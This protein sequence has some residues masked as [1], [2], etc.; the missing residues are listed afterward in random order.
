MNRSAKRTRI[1]VAAILVTV[2]GAMSHDSAHAGVIF[3]TT[4]NDQLNPDG[5]CSLKEAI[6]A[7]NLDS[8][9]ITSGSTSFSTGCV[10]GSGAD[11]I[12]LPSQSVFSMSQIVDD[13]QNPFGPT[14]TPMVTSNITIEAD[15]SRLQ[16]LGSNNV[17]AFAVASTGNLTIRLAHIKG[18][19][20]KGGDGADGGGGGMGAGGAIFV[21]GSGSLTV[22]SC[23]FEGNGAIGGNGGANYVGGGGGGGGLGGNGGGAGAYIFSG[24]GG[25]GGSRGN[26]G[27]GEDGPLAA[28]VGAGGGGGGTVTAGHTVHIPY[29]FGLGGPGGAECGG[30]GG[31]GSG[32]IGFLSADG[33]NGSCPGGGG[34][35]GGTTA[36]GIAGKGG[37][38]ANGNY[39]GGGG[40]G[41]YATGGGTD[42]GNGG[43]GGGGGSG[44]TLASNL[45]GFGPSGGNGGFAGGGGAAHG[46]F[47]SAGPGSGGTFGGNAGHENGGGG[48]GLG[49][50]I[51]NEGGAVTVRNST[52]TGNYAVRGVSGGTG[53]NNGHDAGGT[54]FALNGSTTVENSTISGNEDTASGGGIVVLKTT[55]ASLT[56][57]NT[58]IANNGALECSIGSAAATGSGNLITAND[59]CPGVVTS[60]D[61]LLGPLQVTFPGKL[62]TM[63]LALSSP[64]LN[65]ADAATSLSMDQRGVDRPQGT[66]FDIGAYER[67]PRSGPVLEFCDFVPPPFDQTAHLTTQSSPAVGGVVTPPSGDYPLDSVQAL[68]ATANPGYGFVSW[69][70]NVA[71]PNSNSTFV[72]M[73]QSQTVTANFGICVTRLYGRGVP[74]NSASPPRVDLSWSA[75]VVDHYNVLRS[76]TSGGPYTQVGSSTTNAFSDRTLGLINGKTFYY[77]LQLFAGDGS[78]TCESNETAV[79]IPAA[80]GR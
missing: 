77:R 36:G 12:I 64:A 28:G 23:T 69:T 78:E 25:G 5:A 46:G 37:N 54:I 27:A 61:P 18:F 75:L 2:L 58:I 32:L 15:G 48:G 74:G 55:Q 72:A 21:K 40:G 52:F 66:G 10:P 50:A 63:G 49:G 33:A 39:G 31:P 34:G 26:G 68:S 9:V 35:G 30:D 6:Y 45:D 70:G 41:G 1:V 19:H 73:N 8:N 71:A 65:T 29:T 3:V 13:F 56:L 59:S 57:R 16:W 14:A 62:P 38:G 79:T 53:A 51:F 47:I 80:K 43:F 44:T 42:G 24:G 67:C 22:E 76:P 60:A 4:T 11:R 20:A 7:A 17:R